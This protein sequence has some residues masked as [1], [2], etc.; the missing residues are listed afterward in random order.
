MEVDEADVDAAEEFFVR[1]SAFGCLEKFKME[2]TN[3]MLENS[4]S[5]PSNHREALALYEWPVSYYE[6]LYIL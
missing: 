4:L 6:G 2:C 1:K 5:Y 3:I